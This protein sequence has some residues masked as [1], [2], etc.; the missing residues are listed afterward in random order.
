MKRK[1]ETEKFT[2]PFGNFPDLTGFV[3]I[4][5]GKRNKVVYNS[6]IIVYD[7]VME[8]QDIRETL[9][10]KGLEYHEVNLK[11]PTGPGNSDG[12]PIGYWCPYCRNWEYWETGDDG[13]KR[14]PICGISDSNYYVK[15]F[16]N[17]WSTNMK[18]KA[19]KRNEDNMKKKARKGNKT[20]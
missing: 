19:G 12:E 11:R 7:N 20:A 14:C 13:Y 6:G 9:E 8:V 18:S 3:F 1:R 4:A 17:L 16:N 10:S 2:I 15:L 5:R